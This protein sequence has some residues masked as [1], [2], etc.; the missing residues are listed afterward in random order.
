MDHYY[1]VFQARA[2]DN[3]SYRLEI[4]LACL[5]RRIGASPRMATG[6]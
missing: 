5:G 2:F 6:R 1:N 4:A 3:A